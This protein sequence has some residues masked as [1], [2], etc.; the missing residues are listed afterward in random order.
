MQ[1]LSD[2]NYTEVIFIAL[3]PTNN[4]KTAAVAAAIRRVVV[5]I[6]DGAEAS[7]AVPRAATNDTARARSDAARVTRDPVKFSV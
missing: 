7:R 4:T 1:N 2:K 5:A 3:L 6:G